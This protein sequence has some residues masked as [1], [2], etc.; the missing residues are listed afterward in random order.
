ML[1]TLLSF[2]QVCLLQ[3]LVLEA[4]ATNHSVPSKPRLYIETVGVSL[5]RASPRVFESCL[6]SP[7]GVVPNPVNPLIF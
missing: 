5:K 6:P 7:G 4:I 1:L 3:I 2:P